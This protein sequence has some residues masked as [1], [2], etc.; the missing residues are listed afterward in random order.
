MRSIVILCLLWAMRS[1]TRI[2]FK[3][4]NFSW[5]MGYL[6]RFVTLVSSVLKY[7]Y[8]WQQNYH[9]WTMQNLH[10]RHAHTQ[11]DQIHKSRLSSSR[12]YVRGFPCVEILSRG[13]CRSTHVTEIHYLCSKNTFIYRNNNAEF[14][15]IWSANRSSSI[16]EIYRCG[17]GFF[18][19][20]MVHNNSLNAL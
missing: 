19:A 7:R 15:V 6:I 8:D 14:P 18:I 4:F 17:F 9:F 3:C 13:S 2:S 10:L 20:R 12:H 1:S 11:K 16:Y 5:S